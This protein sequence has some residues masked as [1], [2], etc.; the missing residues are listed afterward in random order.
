MHDERLNQT[1]LIPVLTPSRLE[2]AHRRPGTDAGF[3]HREAALL[4]I[5]R[6]R[7]VQR[8][9]A[10][11]LL[12]FPE[13]HEA[14]LAE[15]F[16]DPNLPLDRPMRAIGH[17]NADTGTAIGTLAEASADLV[18][19]VLGL[20]D[21]ASLP[22]LLEGINRALKPDGLFM[23]AIP[24]NGTLGELR[25]ALLEAE[26]AL[27]SGASVR[28]GPFPELRE[29]GDMLSRAGFRLVVADREERVIRYRDP[30]GLVSDLRDNGASLAAGGSV[31]PLT[32]SEWQMA[33]EIYR[34]R[35]S[36]ADGKVRATAAIGLVTGWKE[37]ASQQKPLRPGS[38]SRKLADFL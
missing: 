6:L 25:H 34:Q 21:R 5:D 4:L 17:E 1:R 7:V 35:F 15:L 9:F 28:V 12:L 38:A 36:D 31:P 19:S 27:R 37:H 13:P 8:R 18:I 22:A 32:R 16:G 26:S 2:R 3:M 30:Q 24:A 10:E 23:A 14:M 29:L 33:A 20:H 11:P